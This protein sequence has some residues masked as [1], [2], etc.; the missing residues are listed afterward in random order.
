MDLAQ[1]LNDKNLKDYLLDDG[2]HLNDMGY[3]LYTSLL[4]QV[5][6]TTTNFKLQ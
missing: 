3:D 2:L 1:E 6:K 4:V 5:I